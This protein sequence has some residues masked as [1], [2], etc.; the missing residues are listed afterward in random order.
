MVSLPLLKSELTQTLTPR[1]DGGPMETDRDQRNGT[2][3]RRQLDSVITP[4]NSTTLST[5]RET[6]SQ[7]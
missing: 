5:S 6:S 1:M 2:E 4:M 3:F 7:A